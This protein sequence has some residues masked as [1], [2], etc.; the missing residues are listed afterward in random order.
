[1]TSEQPP[2][3]SCQLCGGTHPTDEHETQA[4]PE[5]PPDQQER[6]TNVAPEDLNYDRYETEKYDDDIR[7]S[8]PGYEEM[9][10]EIDDVVT[11]Y[12]ENNKVDNVLDL[13]VGTGLTAERLLKF[14]PDATLTAVDFSAQMMKG[15]EKR[16]TY[17]KAK[18]LIGDYSEIDFGKDYE[19]VVSVI[20]L[21]HQNDEG[22]KKMFQRIYDAL[23]PGGIFIFGDLVTYKDPKKATTNEEK[24]FQFLRE[25]ARDEQSLKEWEEHHRE[26]N[27]LAPIEDQIEWLKE[28]GFS[29]VEV[30]FEHLNTALIVAKK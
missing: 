20:G 23:K 30:K 15:A 26:K 11:E 5:S 29:E 28:A 22:K 18:F 16:L 6:T 7:R 13:G 4:R 27:L 12:V 2:K 19:V 24:H 25:N 9:H 8:I 21:H 3:I 17:A 14:T 1:M 10:K